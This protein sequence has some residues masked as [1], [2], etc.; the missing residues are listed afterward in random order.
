MSRFFEQWG[1]KGGRKRARRLSA[2]ERSAIASKAAKARWGKNRPASKTTFS[3]R[4][5]NP[6]LDDPVYVEEVLSEGSLEEWRR[7]YQQIADRPF[8]P[9][10]EA[11]E[12]VLSATQI[13]GVT[14][15]WQG[16]LRTIQGVE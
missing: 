14:P 10:A 9:T 2:M 4:L 3:I 13:Y 16:I 12:R 15:L 6:G 1:R 11:L 8:G 5:D 7:I